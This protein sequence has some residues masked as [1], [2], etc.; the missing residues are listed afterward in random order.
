[1]RRREGEAGEELGFAGNFGDLARQAG[2]EEGGAHA[3]EE[4]K[5]GMDESGAGEP[6][7]SPNWRSG[8]R[9]NRHPPPKTSLL[10]FLP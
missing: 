4:G 2:E 1:M 3:G 9:E 6:S 10:F 8:G 7:V 5:R